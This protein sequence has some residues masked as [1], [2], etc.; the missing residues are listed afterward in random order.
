MRRKQVGAGLLAALLVTYSATARS[1]IPGRRHPALQALLGIALAA[2]VR[3]PL[4]LH[5]VARRTGLRWGTAAAVVVAASVAAGAA[6]PAVR[7]G[8][9]ARNLPRPPWKWLSVEIPFGTVCFEETVYRGALGSLAAAGFGRH[10]RLLQ[11]AAFG[12]S[13]VV[14]ARAVGEPVLATVAVT[15]VA[16]WVL[17]WLGERSGSLVAPMMAHLAVNEAGAVAALWVAR[18]AVDT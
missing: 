1:A 8:M 4:G 18:R 5:G 3:A 12:L 13:H 14:D 9:R 15:G 7:A 2:L 16:G 6:V 10:G 11:A 17:G